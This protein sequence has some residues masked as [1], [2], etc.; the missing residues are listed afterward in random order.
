MNLT[1]L[2][3]E[4]AN[5]KNKSIC[6]IGL[7]CKKNETDE[8]VYPPINL[9]VNPEDGF[10]DFC[11]RIHGIAPNTVADKPTFPQVW[12]EIEKYFVD[13]VIVGHNVATSDID[14]LVK[15]LRRYKI[16]IPKFQYICTFDLAKRHVPEFYVENYRLTTLCEYF[17]I[18]VT[19]AHDAFDD[20]KV[21]AELLKVL[22]KI[23]A[24]DIT[25]CVRCYNP[26]KTRDFS[27]YTFAPLLRRKVTE[28]YGILR[29]IDIDN[30]INEREIAYLVQW[31]KEN[32]EYANDNEISD[33]IEILDEV[34]ADGKITREEFNLLEEA[35]GFYLSMIESAP[36]TQATRVLEGILKGIISDGVVSQTELQNLY[37]WLYSNIEYLSTFPFDKVCE[38]VQTFYTGKEI[39]TE[40]TRDIL[41]SI[42][43]ILDP[44]K[45][46]KNDLC[47]IHGKNICLSGNFAY[48]KKAAVEKYIV[49]LGGAVMSYVGSETDILVVGA[50]RSQAYAYGNYGTKVRDAMDLKN[51]GYAI[52]ILD[53]KD[54]FEMCKNMPVL[55]MCEVLEKRKEKK[56]TPVSRD[57]APVLREERNV[58]VDIFFNF[59]LFD[60]DIEK[61][62]LTE[63]AEQGTEQ[64][65]N[66]EELDALFAEACMYRDGCGGAQDYEEAFRLFDLATEKGHVA[67]QYELSKLYEF[68]RGVRRNKAKAQRNLY[69]AAKHGHTQAQYE[70]ALSYA[71]GTNRYG[72]IKDAIRY[73]KKAANKNHQGAIDWLNA[74]T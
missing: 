46:L 52:K 6:Q 24:V 61:T 4:Y 8:D 13:T 49:G 18:C 27:K 5:S 48:G 39:S 34:L 67:A 43:E 45:E 56:E 1:Y 42:A 74:N 53:E 62:V 70:L 26:R 38:L 69:F 64:T 72:N 21:T 59:D 30:E 71:N 22:L 17:N 57:E 37:H 3:F 19:S 14:A 47:N 65:R 50:K 11:V 36:I 9:Y 10:D 44:V 63:L 60:D 66:N 7:L 58:S 55:D 68:G 51:S 41:S 16:P 25:T 29:G 73:F 23:Y 33:I 32:Q 20:A 28:F 54:F 2:D 15:T 40:E 31:K 12:G 35:V